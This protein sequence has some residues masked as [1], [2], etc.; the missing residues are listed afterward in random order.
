MYIA[1]N[2]EGISLVIAIHTPWWPIITRGAW[3]ALISFMNGLTHSTA[4]LPSVVNILTSK[5]VCEPLSCLCLLFQLMTLIYVSHESA[6]THTPH[7]YMH[8]IF[9]YFCCTCR[10]HGCHAMHMVTD[11]F[12]TMN[13]TVLYCW[14]NRAGCRDWQHQV[15]M[16]L[17]PLSTLST[18]ECK[19]A[20]QGETHNEGSCTYSVKWRLSVSIKY[21]VNESSGGHCEVTLPALNRAKCERDGKKDGSVPKPSAVIS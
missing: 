7:S 18:S 3:L 10:F 4:L 1:V 13:P 21:K 17:S 11:L 6:N 16:I 9:L 5:K 20:N 15:S 8:Y 2:N 12:D 19:H 14:V